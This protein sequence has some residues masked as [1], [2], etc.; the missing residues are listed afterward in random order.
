MAKRRRI[1]RNRIKV[2]LPCREP[3]EGADSMEADDYEAVRPLRPA[4]L[5]HP[6]LGVFAGPDDEGEWDDDEDDFDE[7]NDDRFFADGLDEEEKEFDDDED[8]DEGEDDDD[9]D[10]KGGTMGVG[11]YRS[12]LVKALRSFKRR[13]MPLG[14]ED[15][16]AAELDRPR[17]PRYRVVG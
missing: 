15:D 9:L 4:S 17:T 10:A 11:S 1:D 3:L 16:V 12:R 8:D 13:P 14:L 5:A 6:R 2:L 7:D